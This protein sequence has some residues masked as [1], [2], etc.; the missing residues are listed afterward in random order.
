M[1]TTM[2]NIDIDDLV[3]RV[4]ELEQHVGGF[5]DNVNALVAPLLE[6][7]AT[8][9]SDTKTAKLAA[10][11]AQ[12]TAGAAQTAADNAQSTANASVKGAKLIQ[13]GRLTDSAFLIDPAKPNKPDNL[14]EH[15]VVTFAQ[16]FSD[17]PTVCLTQ[18]EATSGYVRFITHKVSKT[19]F[20]VIN[21][22]H[23]SLGCVVHWIAIG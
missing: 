17:T 5:D 3:R 10:D 14:R 22:D 2:S 23:P 1:V 12:S 4:S 16:P 6:Q 19:G 9:L 18:Q 13:F 8:L 11:I 7:L 20:T 21:R 15:V